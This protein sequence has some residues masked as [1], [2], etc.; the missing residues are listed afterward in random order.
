MIE[1]ILGAIELASAI[2]DTVS[3]IT[4]EPKEL[5]EKYR[6]MRVIV[7]NQT[8]FPLVYMSSKMPHGRFWTT[9][10]NVEAFNTMEF[11]ACNQDNS[12]LTGLEG[13]AI[14][15]LQ[16]SKKEG[17]YETLDISIGFDDPAIGSFSTSA[18]FS[19]SSKKAEDAL[20]S[21]STKKT[22]SALKGKDKKGHDVSINFIATATPGNEAKVTITQ[23]IISR[24]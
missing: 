22:S 16:M 15:Q 12:I 23:Q 17:G 4:A 9:P 19:S 18:L 21:E 8:Q 20:K 10:T 14:F 1:E 13:V 3:N 24:S 7:S 11:S 5:K 2:S 6:S